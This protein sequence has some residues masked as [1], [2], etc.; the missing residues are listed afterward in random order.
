MTKRQFLKLLGSLIPALCVKLP[1]ISPAT[2]PAKPV[3]VDAPIK[4]W[5]A[6][7]AVGKDETV[8]L[9]WQGPY[10]HYDIVETLKRKPDHW[11]S[12]NWG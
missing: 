11:D 8:C 9:V 3:A 7:R 4:T 10:H 5:G 2:T 1:A 12:K 6:D